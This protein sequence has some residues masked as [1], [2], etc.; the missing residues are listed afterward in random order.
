[1]RLHGFTPHALIVNMRVVPPAYLTVAG[2]QYSRNYLSRVTGFSLS[3]WSYLLSGQRIPSARAARRIA[4]LLNVSVPEF[5]QSLPRVRQ[6][7]LLAERLAPKRW[8]PDPAS[9]RRLIAAD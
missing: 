2:V 3:Y 4:R 5:V 7:R 8:L 9:V 6:R 1:M